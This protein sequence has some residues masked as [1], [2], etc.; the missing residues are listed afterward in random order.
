MKFSLLNIDGSK[1]ETLDVSD[2]I[3]KL[4]FSK[5][6]KFTIR[7]DQKLFYDFLGNLNEDRFILIKKLINNFQ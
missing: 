6:N 1:S 4:S 7:S 2:K 5:D 3:M